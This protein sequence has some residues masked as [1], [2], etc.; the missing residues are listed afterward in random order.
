ML[1]NDDLQCIGMDY[2]HC[3]DDLHFIVTDTVLRNG[4]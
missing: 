1:G 2:L 3:N 4:V